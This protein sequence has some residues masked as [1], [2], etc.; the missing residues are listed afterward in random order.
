[1]Q[2]EKIRIIYALL[3]KLTFRNVP[4]AVKIFD[5]NLYQRRK[6]QERKG[7]REREG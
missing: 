1:M 4:V 2:K 7:K 6:I 3:L 5:E